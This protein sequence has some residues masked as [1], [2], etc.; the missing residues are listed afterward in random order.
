[1]GHSENYSFSLELETALAQ[2]VDETSSLLSTQIIRSPDAPSVFHSEFDNFDQ[3]LNNLTGMDSIHTAHGIMMQDTEG[4][5]ED[6][7][8]TCVEMP[9]VTRNTKTKQR[10]LDLP[11]AGCLPDC[12][13]AQR[14]SPQMAVE[15]LTYPDGEGA[16][17][18]ARNCHFLWVL[19]RMKCC[20]SQQVP[21][22]T[23]FI[24][25]T[26]QKPETLTTIDYYPVIASPITDYRTVQECL[27]YA[28][29]APAEVRQQYTITTF[30]LGV[31]M[32]AYPLVWNN[33]ARYEKHT[34]SSLGRST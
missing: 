26:G 6:H 31:C 8:G 23:G 10:S 28:G 13:M 5:P 1:M 27:R 34:S 12:Y 29:D 11:T 16:L 3:L 18:D 4:R 7:G 20:A 17:Q 14:K 9:S 33:P 32:K 2:A 30:D 25:M 19:I 21:G 15:R 24:S 22:W